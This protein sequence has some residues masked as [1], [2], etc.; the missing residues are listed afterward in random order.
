[1]T[2]TPLVAGMIWPINSP[3]GARV[4]VKKNMSSKKPQAFQ[5]LRQPSS[6]KH[7]TSNTDITYRTQD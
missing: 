6:I 3:H 2:V 7:I 5:N 1:M 4:H